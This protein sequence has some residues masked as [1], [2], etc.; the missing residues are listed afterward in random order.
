[1]VTGL[2]KGVRGYM[3]PL[4]PGNPGIPVPS[5]VTDPRL[6]DMVPLT[7]NSPAQW[8]AITGMMLRVLVGSTVHGTAITGQDDRDEMGVCVEQPN[9]VVGLGKF[10]HYEFRTQPD[11]VC[12]GPGDLDL[13]VYGLRR[14][15]SLTAKGNPTVLLPLFVPDDAVC[16]INDFGRELR[17]QRSMF[18]SKQAGAR[19]KGYLHSQRQGLMGLRSGGSRN[20]GRADIRAK[21]GFDSKFAMHMVRLGVQG[22]ELLER[23]TITLPMPDEVLRPLQELRRGEYTKEWALDKA[24]KLEGRIDQ[25]MATTRLPDEPDWARINHWLTD[26]HLRHWRA[27]WPFSASM[28]RS[29]LTTNSRPVLLKPGFRDPNTTI[30]GL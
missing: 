20:Q 29:Q 17:E 9:T 23:G 6:G 14:Y 4:E 16:Y 18:L 8:T 13:I 12:S 3:E 15:A 24:A 7:S 26:V 10:S 2:P 27:V 22:V 19:F 30:T 21:Y 1:M 28:R 25:L 11:G 5:K